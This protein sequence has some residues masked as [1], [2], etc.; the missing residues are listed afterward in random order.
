[1]AA[2]ES[3]ENAR[4]REPALV[5][6]YAVG[7]HLVGASRERDFVLGLESPTSNDDP[8]FCLPLAAFA[9]PLLFAVE[10]VVEIGRLGR[11]LFFQFRDACQRRVPL[12]LSR[13]ELL[14]RRVKLLLSRIELLWERVDDFEQL[15]DG[16][17]PVNRSPQLV[18]I[19]HAIKRATRRS[20]SCAPW[21]KLME[22]HTTTREPAPYN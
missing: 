5:V 15:I 13:I 3:P 1:M 6:G 7:V 10:R 9:S 8:F 21:Q 14:L 11:Q 20:I 19:N 17:G 2:L 16:S 22:N 18:D 4:V 12:L